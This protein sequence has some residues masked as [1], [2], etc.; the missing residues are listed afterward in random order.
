MINWYNAILTLLLKLRSD[1]HHAQI[2]H[3]A[4]IQ[5][6]HSEQPQLGNVNDLHYN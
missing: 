5:V 4:Q 1:V 3:S 6:T 2:I